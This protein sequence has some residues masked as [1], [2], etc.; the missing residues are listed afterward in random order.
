MLSEAEAFLR[1]HIKLL[2]ARNSFGR[3]DL[4]L[5]QIFTHGFAITNFCPRQNN[6]GCG[7]ICAGLN[8]LP[9]KI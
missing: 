3:W 9:E 5:L 7:F 8:R 1:D 6:R 2:P 4:Y